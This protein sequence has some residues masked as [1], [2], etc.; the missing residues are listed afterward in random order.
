M[1]LTIQQKQVSGCEVLELSGR[2]TIGRDCQELEWQLDKLITDGSARIVVDLA[3]VTHVDSTGIGIFVMS[4]AKAKQ[5]GGQLRLAAPTS[6]VEQVFT[7]T[8]VNTIVPIHPTVAE[9]ATASGAAAAG[10]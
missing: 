10:A 7:L 5:H 2:V 3:N 9:A 6:Q 1:A 4:S 8:N